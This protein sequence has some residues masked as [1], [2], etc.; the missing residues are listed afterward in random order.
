MIV[1]S[2]NPD[3]QLL[4]AQILYQKVERDLDQLQLSERLELKTFIF[5]QLQN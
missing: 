1:R 2:Q 3:F 5:K 4:G